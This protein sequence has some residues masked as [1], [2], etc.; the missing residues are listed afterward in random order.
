MRSSRVGRGHGN[1]DRARSLAD[2][3]V[4][5]V[6]AGSASDSILGNKLQIFEADDFDAE[7]FVQSECQAMSEKSM[8]KLCAE[9]AD[10]RRFSAEEMRK[11]VFANYKAFIR[12]AK[13]ISDLEGELRAMRNLLSAQVALIHSLAGGAP[14]IVG[15]AAADERERLLDG[16]SG[17]AASAAAPDGDGAAYADE[18]EPS[19]LD[20]HAEAMPDVLD[21]LLAERKVEQALQVLGQEL[22]AAVAA[23]ARLGDAAR[24][25][26]L[27]L[28]SHGER[29]RQQVRGLRPSGTSYGGAYTAALSQLVF[30]AI[31]QAAKDSVAVFGGQPSHA[32]ELML[33]AQAETEWCASLL[34]RHVLSS[35]AA[36]GGLRSAAEC[37]QIARGHCALLEEQGL[38]LAPVL[39]RLVRPSVEQA[40][41]ANIRRIEEN[42]TA[43]A[44]VDDW[45]LQYPGSAPSRMGR[46]GGLAGSANLRLT[47]SAL[48]L[49]AMLQEFLEDV[50][51]IVNMQLT[52]PTL[53]GLAH[54]FEEYVGML[55]KALQQEEG[56]AWDGVD[57]SNNVRRAHTERQQLA[58]LGNAT[59]LAEEL[60]RLAQ[61]LVQGP[62]LLLHASSSVSS[63][64][65]SRGSEREAARRGSGGGGGGDARKGELQQWKKRLQKEVEQ[66]RLGFASQKAAFLLYPDDSQEP[67]LPGLYFDQNEDQDPAAWQQTAMP[68]D[69][70]Q[71]FF[72]SANSI[73]RTGAEVLAGRDRLVLQLLTQF[74]IAILTLICHS[75]LWE[76]EQ[77]NMG[78]IGLQQ[79]LLDMCFLKEVAA[80]YHYTSR[81][82]QQIA[83]Q[84]MHRA[85]ETFDPDHTVLEEGALVEIAHDCITKLLQS[86][87][88]DAKSGAASNSSGSNATRDA[89]GGGGYPEMASPKSAASFPGSEDSR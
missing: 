52:T 50:V 46:A 39:T 86:A 48:R 25:H 81:Q 69:P 59:T 53:D 60:P 37:V 80:K 34:R 16:D 12:T 5:Q 87:G 21:V 83:D 51:P 27:L 65:R 70:M 58:L 2:G 75:E 38:A 45:S 78:P 56:A 82:M 85:R 30:S 71:F 31:S 84:S 54:L 62:P 15:G 61:R 23:L 64:A 20:R 29:L 6:P 42:I 3:T 72:W 44:A 63:L 7:G 77:Y 49:Y 11:S 88:P 13:E 67:F 89:H 40:L 10:H 74:C 8:R 66:L 4:V 33:W 47:S 55:H 36:A 26:T 9:L 76:D 35:A 1:L 18:A 22:R 43:M 24:A 57:G 41:E 79:F 73:S 32:S 19:A 28:H 17:G 68:T 14:S